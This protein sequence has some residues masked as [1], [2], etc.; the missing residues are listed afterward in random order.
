MERDEGR[1]AIGANFL[2]G[3]DDAPPRRVPSSRQ[4]MRRSHRLNPDLAASHTG[5]SDSY[6]C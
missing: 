6:A 4:A 2:N 5:S 1:A 3:S